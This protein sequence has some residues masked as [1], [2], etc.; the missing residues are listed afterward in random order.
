MGCFG[1][2]DQ[3]YLAEYSL[4]LSGVEMNINNLYRL[5]MSVDILFVIE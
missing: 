5:F 3:I 1:R 4:S 2:S